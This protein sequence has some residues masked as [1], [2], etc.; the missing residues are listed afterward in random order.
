M[1]KMHGF[2]ISA[3]FLAEL[4][5]HIRQIMTDVSIMKQDAGRIDKAFG[6]INILLVMSSSWI[7]LQA[8]R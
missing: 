4:D 8:R 3:N 7:H 5:M 1:S 2:M 6:G